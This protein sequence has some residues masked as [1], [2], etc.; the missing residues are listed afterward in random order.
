M[1]FYYNKNGDDMRKYYIF[2]IKR[3]YNELYS[4]NPYVLYKTLE[5]LYK[6]KKE[7]LIYGISLYNQICNV[8]EVNRLKNY[9]DSICYYKNKNKY[10]INDKDDVAL[11]YIH[12]SCIICKCNKNFPSI[13][14]MMN[15]YS[16]YLFICDF[17]NKDY[18]FLVKRRINNSN[19]KY[20]YV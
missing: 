3:E 6:L 11:F 12:Y 17:E 4:K 19:D 5:N 2:A 8:I 15:Y 9:F 10:L 14:N 1:L 7:D 16:R 13:L 18:F 20:N